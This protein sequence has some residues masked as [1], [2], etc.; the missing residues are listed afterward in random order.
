MLRRYQ[1]W[2]WLLLSLL[3]HLSASSA[4]PRKSTLSDSDLLT[5][6]CFHSC[7]GIEFYRFVRR[8]CENGQCSFA[9]FIC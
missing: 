7:R 4:R 6:V 2:S 9:C 1:L 8:F 3:F 5:I